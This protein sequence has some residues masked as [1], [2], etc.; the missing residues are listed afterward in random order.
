MT[1]PADMST[2]ALGRE[3]RQLQREVAELSC[4]VRDL[5]EAWRTARGL[6]RAVK[7]LGGIA[8][9]VTAVWAMVA[10]ALGGKS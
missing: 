5:V 7:V 3:V 8:T 6:V 9:A 1:E 4:N 2:E 10:M